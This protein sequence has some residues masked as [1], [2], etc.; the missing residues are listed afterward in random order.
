[1]SRQG[2]LLLRV[3]RNII[4]II[5]PVVVDVK[6]RFLAYKLHKCEVDCFYVMKHFLNMFILFCIAERLFHTKPGSQLE[7][8]L[9]KFVS[10]K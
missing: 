4:H 3:N 7:L 8:R 5:V 2:G 6:S 1:M 9:P 10:K